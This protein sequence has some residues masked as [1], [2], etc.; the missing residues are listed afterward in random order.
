MITE[1]VKG[2]SQIDLVCPS[3]YAIQKLMQKGLLHKLDMSNESYKNLS[4][5][6]PEIR[7]KVDEIFSSIPVDGKPS[8]MNDY[9]VPYMWGTL[10]ILYN[11]KYVTENDLEQGWGL[12]WNSGNNPA[13][14]GKILMKDSVR[15]IYAASVIYLKET[16]QLP[17]RYKDY[18]IEEL[19]NTV[20]GELITL[21]KQVLIEQRKNLKGY[22]VDFGKDDMI[23]QIAYVD[24]AWSGDALWAIEESYIEAEDDYLLDYLV[25]ESGG[26]IWFDGWCIP[27]S[28][29]N[30]SAAKM[31]IDFLCRPDI[32]MMNSM[33]IGY[34]CS[35][36]PDV[37]LDITNPEYGEYS[38]EAL[39]NLV[40]N[41]YA[42]EIAEEEVYEDG[43]FIKL[44]IDGETTLY[45]F[46]DF[47][48]DERR[49]PKMNDSLGVMKD[50][51]EANDSVVAMWEHVKGSDGSQWSLLIAI[52]IIVG[53][54]ALVI[55]SCHLTRYFKQ[56]RRLI[57]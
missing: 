26:N 46:T 28:A 4:Y 21:T 47:F 36:N 10:G 43:I 51:G 34:V 23:N 5:V 29:E 22:E 57:S 50:F 42:W 40:D 41:E 25:P 12:L 18:S 31:F 55:L 53:G 32:A 15:D 30:V 49:Y 45:D 20:D 8:A 27:T 7:D 14:V 2:D 39:L 19:I 54:V 37:F 33:N 11:T 6:Y 56:R 16:N 3:E 35:V 9:F 52:G 48:A 13:L 44:E 38:K 24:L 1:V 17:D